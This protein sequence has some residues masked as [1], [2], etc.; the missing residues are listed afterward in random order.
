MGVVKSTYRHGPRNTS[1]SI[2]E[3]LT[4]RRHRHPQSDPQH[5]PSRPHIPTTRNKKVF[6]LFVKFIATVWEGRA[7]KNR[8]GLIKP[9]ALSSCKDR[10]YCHRTRCYASSLRPPFSNTSSSPPPPPQQS[11]I[12]IKYMF[13]QRIYVHICMYWVY[14]K[15]LQ[16]ARCGFCLLI[17]WFW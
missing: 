5:P 11:T 16:I 4:A 8:W 6:M 1:R 7:A 14:M 15:A 17:C 13:F 10:N 12:Y 9:W 3:G 2:W